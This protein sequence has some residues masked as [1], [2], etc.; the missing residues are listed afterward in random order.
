MASLR[1]EEHD[2]R[3][4]W[5]LQFRDVEKRNRSIW[6][7]GDKKHP[8]TETKEHVEHL[9]A[10]I[11]KGRPPELATADWLASIEASN[12]DLHNKLAKCGLV[13]AGGTKRGPCVDGGGV[14]RRIH[15]GTPG[16]Q[17]RPRGHATRKLASNLVEHFGHKK[18][19]RDVTVHGRQEVAG[20]VEDKR[21]PAGQGT[22][23]DG[24]GNGEASNGDGQA[25]LYRGGGTWYDRNQ[26]VRQAGQHNAR[27]RE[28]PTLRPRGSNRGLHASLPV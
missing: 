24:R 27:Q 1:F 2:G 26:P 8:P 14:V 4:G 11:K 6:L 17:E 15:P 25:I 5:R 12:I 20:L 21:Q 16:R 3:H 22:Q 23:D 9:L 10:Q 7:G 13:E 18:L 28:T 19:L